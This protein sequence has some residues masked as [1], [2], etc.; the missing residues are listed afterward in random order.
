LTLG[1]AILSSC[2]RTPSGQVIHQSLGR[3]IGMVCLCVYMCVS[4]M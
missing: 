4:V 1:F 2:A 3:D